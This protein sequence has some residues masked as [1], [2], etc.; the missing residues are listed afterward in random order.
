MASW[1]E[2]A[3]NVNQYMA[4][5][6]TFASPI[7]ERLRSLIIETAPHL[8]EA[9]RWNSP[10]YKGKLL[11]CGFAAFQKHVSLTFWRGAELDD[12]MGY[13][14]H[15]QGQTPMRTAKYTSL[16]Q[17]NE[18]MVKAWL[19]QAVKLD[20]AGEPVVRKPVAGAPKPLIVPEVLQKT[21]MLKK[22]ASA[23]K[24]FESLSASSRR[25]YCEWIASAKQDETVLRRI[26]K[27]LEKLKAGEGLNDTYRP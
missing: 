4:K 15:G 26:T 18:K 22:N 24:T 19:K 2:P 20:D 8:E 23:R 5:L 3:V 6:S 21:L 7:A 16:D 9:I 1:S 25:E 17:L 10:S 11:V 12:P 27:S 13:L 14:S